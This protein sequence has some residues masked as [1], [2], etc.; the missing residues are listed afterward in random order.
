MSAE[1]E[2][3]FLLDEALSFRSGILDGDITFSWRD[4]SGDPGD[5]WEFVCNT[6]A[7]PKA[8]SGVF[9]VTVLHCMYERVSEV[10]DDKDGEVEMLTLKA[11]WLEQKFQRSHEQA[12]QADLEA[13]K[14]Q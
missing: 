2:R 10:A 12:T 7:V 3:L 9:E 13:L 11:I 8:T 14:W 1:D 4:L 5:M 6:K